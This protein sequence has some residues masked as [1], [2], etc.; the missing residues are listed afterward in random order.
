[1]ARTLAA[2]LRL[3][4]PH[5]WVK[6]LFVAAP[7]VFSRHLV[8]PAYVV[9][10]LLAVL[11]FCALSG[12]VYAFNDVRDVELDRAH[13]KKRLR[14]VASSAISERAALIAAAVLAIGALA[15][16]FVLDWLLGVYASVYLL[17]NVAYSLKLK[18]IAFL[19]VTLIASGFILRVLAGAAAIDVPA[20][21]WLLICTALLALFLG[22]GKRA[23]EL[24]WA[25]RTGQATATRAALAGYS[26][27]VVRIALLVLAVATCAAYVAYTLDSRTVQFFGTHRLIYTAPFVLLGIVRFLFL[28]LWWPKDESPT[29]AMLK[30]PWFLLDLAAAVATTI[31]VIY[32]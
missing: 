1:M 15:G 32:A 17:Q 9:R 5:Q 18:Q 16:A 23:H 6:N 24:A 20:S 25:E 10:T 2:L 13:P 26:I 4:R 29:E 19:D 11:A 28:A 7:L 8:D 12:A 30:D 21:H 27:P 3:L 22:L 14:P 31:Y